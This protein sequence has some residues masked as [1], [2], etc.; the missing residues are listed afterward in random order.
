[1]LIA[2]IILSIISIPLFLAMLYI[3]VKVKTVFSTY[4]KQGASCGLTGSDVARKILDANGLTDV[5]IAGCKGM[6][7]DHYNPLKRT[8]YLSQSTI[9]SASIAAISVAAH[10]VGH[11]IQHANGYLPIKIR[12]AIAPIVSI[13]SKLVFPLIIIGIILEQLAMALPEFNFSY[14]FYVAALACYGFYCLFA[15]V[16]L[17]CEYNASS[18]AKDQLIELSLITQDEERIVSRVLGKAAQ[19]Y[20]LSFLYATVRFLRILLILLSNRNRRSRR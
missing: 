8:V 13:T 16:T 10:E 15:F 19:T 5:K 1:M 14:E 2:I 9:N 3:G 18:R 6:L 4:D 12:S 7:T 11:A 17:P 20:L